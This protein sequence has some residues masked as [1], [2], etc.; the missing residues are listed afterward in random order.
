MAPCEGREQ[1]QLNVPDT[2][3]HRRACPLPLSFLYPSAVPSSPR[4][5]CYTSQGSCGSNTPA[6]KGTNRTQQQQQQRPLT[7]STRRP[8]SLMRL[9]ISLSASCS[10]NNSTVAG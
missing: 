9:M 2:N 8:A 3:R 1:E 6:G 7:L 4:L 10:R 5:H